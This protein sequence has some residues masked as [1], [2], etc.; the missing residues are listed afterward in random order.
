MSC[1]SEKV[2]HTRQYCR[3]WRGYTGQYPLKYIAKQK[4]LWA[5]SFFDLVE[6][7]ELLNDINELF[8]MQLYERIDYR[9][10]L[11]RSHRCAGITQDLK[12]L[13][14]LHRI[15]KRLTDVWYIHTAPALC[16]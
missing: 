12:E 1:L 6:L 2:T 3:H 16:R 7:C 8:L 13:A 4:K 5:L 14:I 11:A 10:I 15:V 9:V